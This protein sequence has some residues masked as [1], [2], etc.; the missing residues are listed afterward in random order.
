[1]SAVRPV[2]TL[3]IDDRVK[4]LPAEYDTVCVAPAG[5]ATFKYMVTNLSTGQVLGCRGVQKPTLASELDYLY[6]VRLA[7]L[8]DKLQRYN[9]IQT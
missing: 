9:S 3:W 8:H 5:E 1:M 7:T 6:Q 2:K 4:P